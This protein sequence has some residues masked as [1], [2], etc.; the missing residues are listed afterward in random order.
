MVLVNKNIEQYVTPI[1]ELMEMSTEN[2]LE[3][4][5]INLHY[6]TLQNVYKLEI[7]KL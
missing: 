3:I 2:V 4:A 6:I 7:S 5:A 1:D